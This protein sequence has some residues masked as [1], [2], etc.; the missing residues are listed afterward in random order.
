MG[1]LALFPLPQRGVIEIRG[2]DRSRWLNGMISNEIS[3]LEDDDNGCQAVLL[4]RQGRVIADLYVLVLPHCIWLELESEFTA[5]VIE[6]LGRYV[7][8]DDVELEDLSEKLSRYSIEGEGAIELVRRVSQGLISKHRYAGGEIRFGNLKAIVANYGFGTGDGLQVFLPCEKKDY[9]EELLFESEQTLIRGTEESF[10][11]LRV[12][13]GRPRLGAELDETVLPDEA[14]L[15][16]AISTTKG[17]YVGQEVIARLRSRG[18][19]K[20][21]LVGLLFDE[22]VLAE[23]PLTSHGEKVG[24]VT[25]VVFA[26]EVGVAG[27]GFVRV[28]QSEPG[29]LLRAGKV[30]AEVVPLPISARKRS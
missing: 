14:N 25:S 9:L 5:S 16:E 19:I 23:A 28:E 29:T 22:K 30:N 20:H 27:L 8:A 26:E 10:E 4:S 3:E 15:H 17:C 6:E 13:A 1:H 2:A 7:I 24:E 12:L 11:V 18:K 21:R